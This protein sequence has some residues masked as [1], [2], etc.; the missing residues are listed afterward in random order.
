MIYRY[1]DAIW[2]DVTVFLLRTAL[3]W[4]ITQRAVVILYRRFGTTSLFH[5][6]GSRNPRS[7]LSPLTHYFNVL[8]LANSAQCVWACRVCSYLFNVSLPDVLTSFSASSDRS[9]LWGI[10]NIFRFCKPFAIS[11]RLPV[12]SESET[13]CLNSDKSFAERFNILW[14]GPAFFCSGPLLGKS[15][16]GIWI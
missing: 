5:L 16:S 2:R 10:Q 11:I 9:S 7:N 15:R 6:Q 13:L 4:A 12:V 1:I 14:Y 3:F 8:R